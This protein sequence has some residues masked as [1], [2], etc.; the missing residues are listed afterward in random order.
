MCV[1]DDADPW[2]VFENTVNV[3]LKVR[4]PEIVIEYSDGEFEVQKLLLLVR[5]VFTE[6]GQ[7]PEVERVD[8]KRDTMKEGNVVC[9]PSIRIRFR[10]TVAMLYRIFDCHEE[11]PA[12]LG[13]PATPEGRK[14]RRWRS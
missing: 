6:A 2:F 14:I 10:G 11:S 5:T 4:I 13:R 9:L 7:K 8:S 12:G 3:P 1:A